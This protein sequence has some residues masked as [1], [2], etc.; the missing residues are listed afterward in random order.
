MNLGIDRAVFSMGA[1]QVA[2]A[3]EELADDLAAGEDEAFAKQ[4]D[5]FGLRQ[6]VMRVEHSY[7]DYDMAWFAKRAGDLELTGIPNRN[8]A[9]GVILDM[10]AGDSQTAFLNDS[11]E[12]G[13]VVKDHHSEDPKGIFRI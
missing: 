6:R 3:H 9:P 13:Q 4:F 2:E 5:P 10:V 8:G 7:P 12:Q 1:R 11:K